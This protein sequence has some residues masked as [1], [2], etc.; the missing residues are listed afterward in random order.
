MEVITWQEKYKT[1]I[2]EIDQQHMKLIS[3]LNGLQNAISSHL[4]SLVIAD[5]INS[6]EN[7]TQYHF[8]TEERL[9]AESAYSDQ[10]DHEKRHAD[11]RARVKTLKGQSKDGGDI[12]SKEIVEVLSD[13]LLNH[14]LTEDKK[15]AESLIRKASKIMNRA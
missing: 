6:L 8:E 15:L 2:A 3:I 13:W 9:M 12:S 10:I 5:V 1:G 7:Y 11:F 4:E 14:I